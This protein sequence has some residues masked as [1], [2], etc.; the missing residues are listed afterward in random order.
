M[1]H[2]QNVV[3]IEVFNIIKIT[4]SFQK[5]HIAIVKDTILRWKLSNI[6]G[7]VI[8]ILTS[9]NSCVLGGKGGIVS[10][11]CGGPSDTTKGSGMGQ[12][13][14]N[15]KDSSAANDPDNIKCN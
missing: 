15:V 3:F 2:A 9:T 5:Y 8:S 12:L 11:Q 4:T 14:F 6:V 7:L 13:I 10:V 1:L